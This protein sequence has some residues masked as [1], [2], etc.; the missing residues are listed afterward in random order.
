MAEKEKNIVGKKVEKTLLFKGEDVK[1]KDVA[2]LRI[3]YFLEEA[4]FEKLKRQDY[5]F[6]LWAKR[7][8]FVALG[9][10]ISLVSKIIAFVFNFK[11]AQSDKELRA[12][13][14]DIQLW[15]VISVGVIF[16]IIGFLYL[17]S[18]WKKSERDQLVK[19]ISNH[20]KYN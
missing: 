1:E 12:L 17:I 4:E 9:T 15:E 18:Y 19:K 16:I 3:P 14:L 7:L 8:L 6:K 13:T 20:F 2:I 5:G 10:S 11:K